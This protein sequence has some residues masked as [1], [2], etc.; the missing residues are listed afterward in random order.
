MI[1]GLPAEKKK[2]LLRDVS[3]ASHGSEA[4]IGYKYPMR[5]GRLWLRP[6][7]TLVECDLVD[8][9]DPLRHFAAREAF[10]EDDPEGLRRWWEHRRRSPVPSDR[11]RDRDES[12]PEEAENDQH[13]DHRE[14]APDAKLPARRR[15]PARKLDGNIRISSTLLESQGTARRNRRYPTG[16]TWSDTLYYHDICCGYGGA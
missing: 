5:Y 11:M 6:H 2:E 3:A 7:A 10:G 15:P 1:A 14:R 16:L 12:P 9:G 13:R 4:R 8:S